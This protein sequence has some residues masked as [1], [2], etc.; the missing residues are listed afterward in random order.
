VSDFY[1]PYDALACEQQ[2][3]LIHLIRDFNHDVHR[4]PWDEELKALAA[5]FGQVLRA[6]VATIDQHGLN[7]KYLSKHE[8]EVNNFFHTVSQPLYRSE[9]AASY[10]KR[11]TKYRHKLF[12]F[13]HHD[14]IP[15]NN[16]NAEHALKRFAYYRELSNGL[17]TEVGLHEYLVLL[18]ICVSCK[19]K[20]VNFLQFLVS[21]E[22]N[23]DVF[24]HSGH[25][26]RASPAVEL[27]PDGFVF[28]RRKKRPPDWD[29][30][31]RRLAKGQGTE[32]TG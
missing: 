29:Q 20:D 22:K 5:D 1:A 8:Q 13:L 30:G 14:G 19:Y 21:R 15:W 27:L 3:C 28:S 18:S 31:H 11:F 32:H 7:K 17:L 24:L 2:K 4:H 16:N 10:Q 9:V 6:I 12:T 26:R 25:Q 23:I